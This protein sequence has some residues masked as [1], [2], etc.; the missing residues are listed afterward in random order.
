MTTSFWADAAI[1]SAIWVC[2]IHDWAESVVSRLIGSVHL[3]ATSLTRTTARYCRLSRAA[4]SQNSV[5]LPTPCEPMNAIFKGRRGERL[6]PQ[7]YGRTHR[8]ARGQ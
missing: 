6:E 8:A 7:E 4:R 2:R 5:D 1:S 3:R